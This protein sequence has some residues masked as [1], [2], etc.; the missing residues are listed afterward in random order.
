VS[1]SCCQYRLGFLCSNLVW[2]HHVF[3]LVL[4]WRLHLEYHSAFV[5]S[6]V[7]Y[8]CYM[9][10]ILS[11]VL[12]MLYV[13]Y[14]I[15]CAIY[16]LSLTFVF[17]SLT[18]TCLLKFIHE[19]LNE[20]NVRKQQIVPGAEWACSKCAPWPLPFDLNQLLLWLLVSLEHTFFIV[21]LLFYFCDYN[22]ITSTL[23]H[24]SS[25][26]SFSLPLLLFRKFLGFFAFLLFVVFCFVFVFGDRVYLC[27][28]AI[29]EL[30]L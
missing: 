15:W 9:C 6:D 20:K 17:L 25:P 19:I 24:F 22:R 27:M 10:S 30:T 12:Y 13:L 28:L 23:F 16:V 18:V 3:L 4:T 14:I 2:G 8:M 26:I 29:L 21:L 7:S 1:C 5:L 11:D